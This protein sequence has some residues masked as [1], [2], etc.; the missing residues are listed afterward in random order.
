MIGTPRT[1]ALAGDT[2]HMP[3]CPFPPVAALCRL[4]QSPRSERAGLHVQ[5]FRGKTAYSK[6]LLR[7]PQFPLAHL[8]F[9]K[10]YKNNSKLCLSFTLCLSTTFGHGTSRGQQ[11]LW[12]ALLSPISSLREREK[13]RGSRGLH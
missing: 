9:E 3:R 13:K 5:C 10:S 4:R 6:P 8:S 2:Q 7:D 12:G 11:S 1:V